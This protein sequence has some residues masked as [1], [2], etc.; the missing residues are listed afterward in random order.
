MGIFFMLKMN[1]I[2]NDI[3]I[4]R[5]IWI[6]EEW[7]FLDF[8]FLVMMNCWRFWEFSLKILML[9]RYGRYY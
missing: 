3:F 7:F 8:I 9:Y 5:N 1:L 2:L 6:L 4:Y